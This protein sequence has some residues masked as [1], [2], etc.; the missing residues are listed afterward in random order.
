MFV[1]VFDQ[2]NDIRPCQPQFGWGQA[3]GVCSVK[4]S[5]NNQLCMALGR[6]EHVDMYAIQARYSLNNVC[7]NQ[8]T[9]QCFGCIQYNIGLASSMDSVQ[10]QLHVATT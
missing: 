10:V 4:T 9:W 1:L 3:G 7:Y 2:L 6:P 8:D 5:Y